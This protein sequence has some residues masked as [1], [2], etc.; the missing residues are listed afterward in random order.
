MRRKSVLR[1]EEHFE[2][3]LVPHEPV[4]EKLDSVTAAKELFVKTLIF[5]S[6]ISDVFLFLRAKVVYF[7]D[8]NFIFSE[9][10]SFIE[11]HDFQVSGLYSLFGLSAEDVFPF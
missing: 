4:L 8:L 11:T 9:G 1:V 2:I 7:V 5:D 6:S 10:A 3:D